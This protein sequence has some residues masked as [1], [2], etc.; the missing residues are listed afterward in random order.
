MN[1]E[2]S[3]KYTDIQHNIILESRER[4]NIS[5]VEDVE[6]FDENAIILYTSRGTLI[7]R[8]SDL[9]IEKLTRDGGELNVQG[10]IDSLQ[11]ENDQPGRGGLFSRLFK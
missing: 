1:Y 8:G 6:S 10:N 9:H 5:G 3:A 4:L 2:E 7:V 11:Y